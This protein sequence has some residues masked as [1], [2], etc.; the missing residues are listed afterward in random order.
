MRASALMLTSEFCA[1]SAWSCAVYLTTIVLEVSGLEWLGIL[2]EHCPGGIQEQLLG[3]SHVMVGAHRS[4]PVCRQNDIAL[5]VP[6]GKV[7]S[8]T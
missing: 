8:S 4:E 6:V 2:Y 7:E 3:Q 5:S 1:A